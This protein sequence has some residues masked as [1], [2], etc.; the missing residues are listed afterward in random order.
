MCHKMLPGQ[1]SL[2]VYQD[3]AGYSAWCALKETCICTGVGRQ[4]VTEPSQSPWGLR[5]L[6]LLCLCEDSWCEDS[7]SLLN[8]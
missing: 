1:G 8:F 4:Q 5:A 7:C 3:I 6:A 2:H